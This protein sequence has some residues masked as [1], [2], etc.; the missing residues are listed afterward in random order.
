MNPTISIIIA[1]YNGIHFLKKCIPSIYNTEYKSYEIIICDD[2]STDGSLEYLKHIEKQYSNI[3]IIRNEKNLGAAKSRNNAALHAKGKYL[4]FL[5]ND[6][7][8]NPSW[9]NGLSDIFES[10]TS[11]GAVQSILIDYH[12]T[13]K[14]QLTGIKL[15]PH[16]CWGIPLF[17]D[18]PITDIPNH[19]QEII[20]LSAALAVRKDVFEK[21]TGFDQKLAVYTEDLELSLRIWIAGF[22]IINS[23]QSHVFHWS[24]KIE[25]RKEMHATRENIYFHLSKNSLR[26]ITKNYQLINVI[27]FLPAA[28]I[29]L[30]I[31]SVFR[32]FKG[33]FSAIDGTAKGV[34]WYIS[35]IEDTLVQR[36]VV[37]SKL[38]VYQ[39]GLIFEKV[40]TKENLLQ[41]YKKYF[42]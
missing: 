42:K 13:N 26:T 34:L 23:P 32:I 19:P 29:I 6:T 41:I 17:K 9:L 12:E 36:K 24:K 1:T 2:C 5:D 8:V 3:I 31:R 11:I 20:A 37:Q 16:V 27:K 18:Q 39:D 25:D 30:F 4:F 38:R 14:I 7:E 10:D 35:N 40:F 28:F 21:I 22:R 33:D 15:I